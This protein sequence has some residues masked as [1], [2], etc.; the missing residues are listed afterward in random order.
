MFSIAIG[1]REDILVLFLTHIPS[2]SF[3]GLPPLHHT[4]SATESEVGVGDTISGIGYIGSGGESGGSISIRNENGAT[5]GGF[6][7][8]STI[9]GSATTV[10]SMVR[11]LLSNTFVNTV[12]APF[13]SCAFFLN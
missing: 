13:P 12:E 4:L 2:V 9:T 5:P 6:L 10:L 1:K 3:G 7:A 11:V 8:R